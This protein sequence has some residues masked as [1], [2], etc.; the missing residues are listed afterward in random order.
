MPPDPRS[1]GMFD[2]N[3]HLAKKLDPPLQVGI[4]IYNGL[5]DHLKWWYSVIGPYPQCQI[6]QP[7]GGG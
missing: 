1:S 3:P 7:Q 6:K 5:D 2:V 4:Y